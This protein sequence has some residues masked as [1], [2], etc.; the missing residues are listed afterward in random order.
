MRRSLERSP[1]HWSVCYSQ[2]EGLSPTPLAWRGQ[3]LRLVNE[4]AASSRTGPLHCESARVAP[5]PSSVSLGRVGKVTPRAPSLGHA[6]RA[7]LRTG[8]RG[9]LPRTRQVL[10]GAHLCGHRWT[11]LRCSRGS[12]CRLRGTGEELRGGEHVSDCL[13]GSMP[14]TPSLS[15]GS[16]PGRAYCGRCAVGTWHISVSLVYLLWRPPFLPSLPFSSLIYRRRVHGSGSSL[17][18]HKG[19]IS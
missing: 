10:A 15:G 12:G 14:A 16:W 18:I 6:W 19:F 5:S 8:H 11:W 1:F 17:Q 7:G 4:W 3:S 13:S 2:W 9:C